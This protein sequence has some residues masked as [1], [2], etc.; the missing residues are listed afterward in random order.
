[1]LSRSPRSPRP[2]PV[3]SPVSTSLRRHA[4]RDGLALDDLRGELVREIAAQLVRQHAGE[5]LIE[6]DAERVA[7]RWSW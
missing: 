2:N 3:H 4:R 5:K 6:H 1:M 7:R